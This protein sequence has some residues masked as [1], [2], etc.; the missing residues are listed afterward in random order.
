M[1]QLLHLV[2]GGELVDPQRSEFRNVEDDRHRRHL[3]RLR[4]G[5]RRLE[6]RAPRRRSTTPTCATSSRTCTGCRTRSAPPARP[7]SWAR[8]R[9]S[10]GVTADAH[11]CHRSPASDA[12]AAS[13]RR[14]GRRPR[15]IPRPF[16]L[17]L[18]LAGVAPGGRRRG[19]AC[20]SG[21]G[22]EG[23]E[24]AGRL[25]ERMGEASLPRPGGAARL[26]PRRQR[27]RGGLAPRDA[28]PADPGA[29]AGRLPRHHRHRDLGAV[30]R[31]PA[32]GELPAPV[33][34]RWTCCPGCR[35]F[36]DHWRPDLAVWTESELWPATL[37]E[38]RA[39]GIPMLLI[40]ARISARSFRR[41][42]MMPRLAAAL[43]GALRPHPR[44]GRAGRRAADRA[45][46]RPGAALGRGHA[47][48]GRRALALRRGRA[49]ADRARAQR[50]AGLARGLDA[51]RRGRDR[52]RRPRPR[53]P[54]A[55]RCWR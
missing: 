11:G 36:L 15:R 29:A 16:L 12:R 13:A 33:S 2:F 5:L 10:G 46:R 19:A 8:A 1:P 18:Y 43:L 51:S 3:P 26:V 47:E 32:A 37:T 28:A 21:G 55:C 42:R 53:A 48:G 38:T 52:A 54:R 34:C 24:D 23:K 20:S 39:R 6:V 4:H 9:G 27:R 45:R 41:W 25:G 35:R 7:R 31:R 49:G 40:N 44:P 50:A 30:P 22:R 14:T 17:R